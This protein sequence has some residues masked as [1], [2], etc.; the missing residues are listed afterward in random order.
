MSPSWAPPATSS[1]T[2]RPS[3]GQQDSLA[4]ALVADHRVNNDFELF[5]IPNVT[6]ADQIPTLVRGVAA[7]GDLT[8]LLSAP[9]KNRA[10]GAISRR[11]CG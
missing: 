2:C 8:N 9:L 7:S 6:T 1:A 5:R 4:L 11:P 3:R 10:A